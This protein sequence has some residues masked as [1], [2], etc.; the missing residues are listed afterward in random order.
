VV[1]VVRPRTHLINFYD[2][3]S[4]VMFASGNR[5]MFYAEKMGDMSLERLVEA[6]VRNEFSSTAQMERAAG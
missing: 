6:L 2:S 3:R 5:R 1:L 4:V